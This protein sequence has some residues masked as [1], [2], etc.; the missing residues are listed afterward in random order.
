MEEAFRVVLFVTE[1]LQRP[2]LQLLG[3]LVEWRG[4][5]DEV[6]GGD[7]VPAEMALMHSRP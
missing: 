4:Q 7:Y 1:E 2:L 3:L 6:R 5:I